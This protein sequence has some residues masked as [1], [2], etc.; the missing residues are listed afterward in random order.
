[1]LTKRQ[2]RLPGARRRTEHAGLAKTKAG[3]RMTLWASSAAP[4]GSFAPEPAP[5]HAVPPLGQ[6]NATGS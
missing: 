3:W 6:G 5:M 2:P 4:C 1:M